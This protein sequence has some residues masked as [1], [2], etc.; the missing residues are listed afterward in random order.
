MTIRCK[1][2][3]QGIAAALEEGWCLCV[4]REKDCCLLPE[5]EKVKKP[6]EPPKP[7]KDQ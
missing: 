7:R 6:D 5:S 2:T 3:G 4:D 1:L